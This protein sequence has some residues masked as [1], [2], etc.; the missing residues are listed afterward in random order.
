MAVLRSLNI[1][2]KT[3]QLARVKR[4]SG[5][6]KSELAKAIEDIR[7]VFPRITDETLGRYIAAGF[8]GDQLKTAIDLVDRYGTSLPHIVRWTEKLRLPISRIKVCLAIRNEYGIAHMSVALLARYLNHL[9]FRDHDP[10]EVEEVPESVL[11]VLSTFMDLANRIPGR[12]PIHRMWHRI[13]EVFGSNVQEAYHM[14]IANESIFIDLIQ[15]KVS[16]SNAARRVNPCAD[17]SWTGNYLSE[18]GLNDESIDP[19]TARV[20]ENL[21]RNTDLGG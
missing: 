1:M 18:G 17:N 5:L 9:G 19:D 16:R 10:L 14:A 3:N 2:K 13:E 4:V 11:E 20:I 8:Y 7:S 12:F 6:Q 15:G 21:I